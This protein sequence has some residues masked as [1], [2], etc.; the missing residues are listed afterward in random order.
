MPSAAAGVHVFDHEVFGFAGDFQKSLIFS[1][2]FV[3]EG[4]DP[5]RASLVP[6]VLF[7]AEDRAVVV[8]FA[9]EAALLFVEAADVP[10]GEVLV[11]QAGAPIVAELFEAHSGD[12]ARQGFKSARL[13]A[14]P[15]SRLR[16]G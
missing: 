7:L 12:A 9:D 13:E 14:R 15:R 5:D 2:V 6:D 10:E 16:S 11:E 3:Q 1:E 4:I 8:Q